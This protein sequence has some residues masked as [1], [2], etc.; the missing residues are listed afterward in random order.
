MP[1]LIE[2]FWFSST[3]GLKLHA[4]SAGRRSND[5]LPAICLPGIS[6]TAE[7]FR[8]LLTAF[9]ESGRPRHALALDSRGRGLSERDGNPANYSIPIELG[10]LVKLLGEQKIERAVFI[11]TSRGGL[12]T[13][14]LATVMPQAIASAVLNDIGPVLDSAG[15]MR[16]KGYVG[17]IPPPRSWPEA[18]A[19]LK[20]IMGSQFPAFSEQDWESYACR[21]WNDDFSPRSDPA[22]AVAF[23]GIDAASP[24]PTL[25]PQFEAL[26]QAAPVLVL[27]GEHSDLLSRETADE[28]KRRG[29]QVEAIEIAGQGHAPAIERPETVARI[30]RFIEDCDRPA[31]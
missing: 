9:A 25:W 16:I 7:D 26:A 27:R 19:S 13:M 23:D 24:L 31:L 11:G 15:I 28:M 12:L 4:L 14:A 30:L 21:T 22:L 20:R 1:E 29:R 17:K 2:D 10:D 3:D 18:V 8:T 5:R 6:R